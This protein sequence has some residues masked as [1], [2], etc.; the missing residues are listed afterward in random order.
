MAALQRI[1]HLRIQADF[2]WI[3]LIVRQNATILVGEPKFDLS[4]S[5]QVRASRRLNLAVSNIDSERMVVNIRGAKGRKN[6]ISLFSDNLLQLLRKYYKEHKPKKYLFK[7]QKG[8]KHS[9]TSVANIL[10]RAALKAGIRKKVTPHMLRHGFVI[11]LFEQGT[12]LR[13][14]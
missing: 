10:K 11:H 1:N 12:D 14:I 8:D 4:L 2:F 6:K 5:W 3:G 13:Y 9:A 7:G